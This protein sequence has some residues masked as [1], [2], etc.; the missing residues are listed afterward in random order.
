MNCVKSGQKSG[1]CV[2]PFAC[3]AIFFA[4]PHRCYDSLLYT[5]VR[6]AKLYECEAMQS[7]MSEVC[8]ASRPKAMTVSM[9]HCLNEMGQVMRGAYAPPAMKCIKVRQPSEVRER[10]RMERTLLKAPWYDTVDTTLTA[11]FSPLYGVLWTKG[12]K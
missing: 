12:C 6:G 2:A 9:D 4:R 3:E 7:D 11:S 5:L 10:S 1:M 8:C